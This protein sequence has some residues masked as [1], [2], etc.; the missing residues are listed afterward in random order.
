MENKQNNKWVR[1]LLPYML[2]IYTEWVQALNH[3]AVSPFPVAVTQ[4]SPFPFPVIN[5]SQ[6]STLRDEPFLSSRVF[7]VEVVNVSLRELLYTLAKDAGVEI[8]IHSDVEEK[9]S[10]VAINQ[11]FSQILARLKRMASIRVKYEDEKK[12]VVQADKPYY[13]QYQLD[14]LNVERGLSVKTQ[15]AP[16]LLKSIT[17]KTQLGIQDS[18]SS[19]MLLEGNLKNQ[20]WPNLKRTLCQALIGTSSK[21]HIS[22]CKGEGE[23]EGAD[24]VA[25][26]PEAGLISLFGT[27]KQHEVLRELLA[28]I[29]AR[30]SRQVLIEATIVEVELNEG[31]ETGVD[32]SLLLAN[33]SKLAGNFLANNLAAAPFVF[34]SQPE[35]QRLQMMIKALETFG[36]TKVLSSPRVMALNNQPALLKVVNEE[37]Y[38]TVEIKEDFNRRKERRERREYSFE[39]HLHSVPIGVV[40]NVTPQIGNTGIISLHVRP[41]ITSI[42]G[43]KEDPAVSLS[44]A[45]RDVPV[46]SQVPILQV[47]EFDSML[48][49][50]DQHIAIL[51][52][53]IRDS[54]EVSREGLPF[55]SR[56][57]I[58]G[59]LFSYQQ[60]RQKKSELIIFLRP[61]IVDYGN[62]YLP[63]NDHLTQEKRVTTGKER[64]L[65]GAL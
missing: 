51:G 15:I 14:Y 8:D 49:I 25:L 27:Q 43:Y 36:H 55:L 4:A 1:F 20:F 7:N 17:E 22:R 10:L 64:D 59:G 42:G 39:S 35:P 6:Q 11:T 32:W 53:L 37:V 3:K 63:I 38:F 5:S 18:N 50:P 24:D 54:H 60:K 44:A 13:Q 29:Q 58:L 56:L 61:K 48:S 45:E 19:S 41:T 33:G 65:H 40:M 62:T 46:K 34:F 26:Y 21:G 16:S 28:D 9:V 57:P 2:L 30:V 52:G 31:Y 23:K 12:I 47:R